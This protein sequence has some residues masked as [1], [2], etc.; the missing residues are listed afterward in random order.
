MRI[1]VVASPGPHAP[2]DEVRGT[3]TVVEGGPARRLTVALRLM[4]V[5]A[6]VRAAARTVDGGVLAEGELRAGEGHAF[7]IALPADAVPCHAAANSALLWMAAARVDR[8][9]PDVADAVVLDV[10][11][12]DSTGP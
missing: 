4:E 3:V 7:R 10:R 9:G 1:A 5:T 6:T 2:G 11:L 12:P 8:R